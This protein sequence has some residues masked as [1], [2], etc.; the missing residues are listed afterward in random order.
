MFI[1]LKIVCFKDKTATVKF[2]ISFVDLFIKKVKIIPAV[3]NSLP[4]T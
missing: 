4:T 1:S 2:I 3:K